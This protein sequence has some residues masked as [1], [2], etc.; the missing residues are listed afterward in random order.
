MV[1]SVA[2]G[3]TFY[4]VFSQD[5]ADLD[6]FIKTD[7]TPAQFESYCKE[8]PTYQISTDTDVGFHALHSAV[9]QNNIPLIEY[10]TQVGGNVFL[11]CGV[12]QGLTPLKIAVASGKYQVVEKLV[13]LGADVNISGREDVFSPIDSSAFCTTLSPDCSTPLQHAAQ[14]VQN[15]AIVRLLVEYG[16]NIEPGLSLKGVRLVQQVQKELQAKRPDLKKAIV[17]GT[18]DAMPLALVDLIVDFII[19]PSLKSFDLEKR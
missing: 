5:G 16:A 6:L 17:D 19:G 12:Y 2:Q 1:P 9:C 3:K 18:S 7:T 15:I 14:V 11:N 4:N 13:E 10:I 8:H